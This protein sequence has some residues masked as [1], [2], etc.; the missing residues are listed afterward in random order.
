MTNPI[1]TCG[2]TNVPLTKP[3][4]LHFNIPFDDFN[5]LELVYS[6]FEHLKIPIKHID[7]NYLQ[8]AYITTINEI[9]T[10][11]IK[12]IF[13][14]F[15]SLRPKLNSTWRYLF[16]EI[17]NQEEELLYEVLEIYR[18]MKL[19]VYVHKTMRGYHFLS[20]KPICDSVFQW[21][22][23]NIRRTNPKYP[24]LT[25]RI[26]P[27]KYQNEKEI[28]NEGF[29]IADTFHSDTKYLRDWIVNQDYV[30]LQEHYQIVWYPL[31]KTQ[32]ELDNMSFEQRLKYEQEQ[33][34]FERYLTDNHKRVLNQ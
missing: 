12:M 16:W 10:K 28:W 29:I 5:D 24:P 19:P 18:F 7:N 1:I 20:V 9:D 17:D 3:A 34:D 30:K 32:E 26:K 33:I 4:K 11:V 8:M 6:I 13:R 15:R 22:I 2:I 31:K 25:L 14:N 23:S 21:C 27:N